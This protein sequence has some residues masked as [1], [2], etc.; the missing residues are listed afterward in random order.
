MDGEP[1]GFFSTTPRLIG[2]VLEGRTRARRH[3]FKMTAW[4]AHT[5]ASLERAKNIPALDKIIGGR[6][7]APRRTR[8]ASA[9]EL[10]SCV[11]RWH[12]ALPANGAP[13]A[14]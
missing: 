3:A 12:G 7:L 10:L 1:N 2:L 6:D 5:V 4:L 14:G 9:D 11:R 8:P 13:R